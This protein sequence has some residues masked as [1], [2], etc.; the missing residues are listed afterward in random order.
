[1]PERRTAS[2][3][4][5]VALEILRYA[6]EDEEDEDKARFSSVEARELEPLARA[7]LE[8][9]DRKLEALCEILKYMFGDLGAD[10]VMIFSTF[11]GT[12]RYLAKELTERGYSLGLMYGPTPVRDEDCRRGER[13]RERIAAEF[14]K[15]SF[16]F[17]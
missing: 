14:G 5:A 7:A 11:R 16:R 4:P 15:A 10:R 13:S 8:S 9:S 6:V 2:C 17:C 3:A 12:L 1:M